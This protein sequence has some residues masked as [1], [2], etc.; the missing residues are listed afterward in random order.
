MVSTTV[1]GLKQVSQSSLLSPPLPSTQHMHSDWNFVLLPTSDLKERLSWFLW[2]PALLQRVCIVFHLLLNI[3]AVQNLSPL[4]SFVRCSMTELISPLR[5]FML[6]EIQSSL[7]PCLQVDCFSL[8]ILPRLVSIH[9]YWA[10]MHVS[11]GQ[12]SP[13]GCAPNNHESNQT[14]YVTMFPSLF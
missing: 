14:W 2:A 1:T 12:S 10:C 11:C 8:V 13:W 4:L 9:T 7:N 5:H 6:G 3:C